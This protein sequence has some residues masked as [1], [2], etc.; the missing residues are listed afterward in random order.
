MLW[1]KSWLETRWR[2]VTGALL[3]MAS[4]A[5][6]VFT[7]PRVLELMPLVPSASV[8]GEL[9]RQIREAVELAREYRG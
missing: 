4:A 3:V 6:V 9:G 1:Y 8:G 2:F 7:Y 5:S